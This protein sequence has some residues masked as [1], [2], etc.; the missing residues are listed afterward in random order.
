[1]SSGNDAIDAQHPPR[2]AHN[3]VNALAISVRERAIGAILV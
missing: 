3:R 2:P 1:M